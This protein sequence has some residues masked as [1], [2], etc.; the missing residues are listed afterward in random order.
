M[1]KFIAAAA[2]GLLISASASAN[3]KQ[4]KAEELLALMNTRAIFD[5]TYTQSM[6]PLSCTLIMTPADEENLK[7]EFMEIADLDALVKKL[8]QFWIQNYTEQELD[9]L[10]AF[11]KTDLGKKSISLL[12]QYTQ[13]TIAELQKWGQEKGPQFM[14]LGKKLAQKY[15][16]RSGQEIEACIK[17]KTGM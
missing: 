9:Q 12:P 10:I 3:T 16:K 13:V 1:K 11:Y 15:P 7:K 5:T 8:S 14:E 6:M 4:E 2:L 17:S